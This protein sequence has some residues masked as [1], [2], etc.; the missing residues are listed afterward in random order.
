[1]GE[2]VVVGSNSSNEA[3]KQHNLKAAK[4]SKFGTFDSLFDEPC[5]LFD[6]A[7]MLPTHLQVLLSFLHVNKQQI[8]LIYF[9]IKYKAGSKQA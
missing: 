5:S 1:M 7:C 3:Y 9:I 4:F 8:N 6:G 2:F